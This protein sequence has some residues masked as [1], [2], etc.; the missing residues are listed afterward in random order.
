M[1]AD[2][3]P[4]VLVIDDDRRFAETLAQALQRR[5][6]NAAVAH[7]VDTALAAARAHRP[8]AAIVDLKLAAEDGLTL[9]E[10]LRACDANMRIVVLTGYASI[11][12]AVK[13]IKL[14]ADDYLA[15]PVTAS[16]VADALLRDEPA[17]LPVEAAEPMSPRRLEWEHIQ[18][19]LAEHAGNISETARA[20]KMH[21]RTL[22]RKLSKRPLQS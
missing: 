15:K 9:V 4:S 14:G 5:G 22:Q 17:A 1:P 11:A 6:W 20:L 3:S 16:A 13:A 8:N 19:V 21:R 12:T 18:R 10:P 7:T 2:A